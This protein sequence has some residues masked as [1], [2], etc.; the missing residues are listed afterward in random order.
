MPAYD[1]ENVGMRPIRP[2]SPEGEERGR[3]KVQELIAFLAPEDQKPPE[4]AVTVNFGRE[5]SD[6]QRVAAATVAAAMVEGFR[7]EEGA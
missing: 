1:Y 3:A 2:L 4:D 7:Q 6:V 5:A